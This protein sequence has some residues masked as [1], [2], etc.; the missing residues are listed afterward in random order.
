MCFFGNE[1]LWDREE[2]KPLPTI[3]YTL[4]YGIFIIYHITIQDTLGARH[5]DFE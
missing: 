4:F 5:G 3:K 1:Q 2:Q